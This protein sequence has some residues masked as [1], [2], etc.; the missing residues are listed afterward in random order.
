[1]KWIRRTASV[2]LSLFL[3]FS[4]AQH[5]SAADGNVSYAGQAEKFIF[6]PGSRYS[7]TDL[8]PNFKD[9][10]PGDSL[11]QRIHVRNKASNRVKIK[12]YMRALGAHE[13][14]EAFL[15]Q[16]NLRVK[17]AEDTIMF[18][19]AADQT[20]QLT[21]W[22]YLGTLYSGGSVELDVTL[23]VPVTMGNDFK[24]AVGYLDWEFMIEELPKEP[25]DPSNP[26]TGDRIA[27]FV[28]LM[29]GSFSLMILL[30][31]YRRKKE[32]TDNV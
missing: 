10:M 16:M 21:E 24:N 13:G 14:S 32:D 6:E 8:F 17:K 1:M 5:V 27:P 12:V 31:L 26:Q 29:A 15:S 4:A 7:P 23:D 25:S 3:I 11:T 20:A 19:A 9:V 18:D 22:T 28:F 2:L 30:L